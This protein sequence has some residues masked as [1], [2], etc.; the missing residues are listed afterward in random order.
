MD[1][2]KINS[3]IVL[4]LIVV[5]VG[6]IIA[7]AG[8]LIA[9]DKG[10]DTGTASLTFVIILGTCIVAYLAILASLAHSI[11]PWV[12]KKLPN[13]QKPAVPIMPESISDEKEEIPQQSIDSIRQ[14]SE[15]R[16]L[17][18]RNAKISL[19]L[20]YAH[21]TMAPH[22]TDDELLRLDECIK[23]FAR[24][25]SLPDNLILI[26]PRELKNPDMFHF[27]WNLAHYF[28]RDKQDVVSWLQTVFAELGKLSPST[29]KGKLYDYQ[30]QK[31]TIPNTDDIP[32]YMS[33]NR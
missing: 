11:I 27:G 16:Y 23:C 9:L 13:K 28:E 32:K 4:L 19:F 3:H 12:M 2:R 26:K 29:I 8:R 31:Y 5:I 24:K 17:E 7:M 22:I 18:K 6:L 33:E 10:F 14:D 30:T 21:L 15:K 20:E 1:Y 25:E